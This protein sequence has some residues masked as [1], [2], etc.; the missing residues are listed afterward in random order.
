MLT[1]SSTCVL[2][3]INILEPTC[4]S[5]AAA[6]GPAQGVNISWA[7][8]TKQNC[9]QQ[10]RQPP[11]CPHPLMLVLTLSLWQSK[12]AGRTLTQHPMCFPEIAMVA[13]Q[14]SS[15]VHDTAKVAWSALRDSRATTQ[16]LQLLWLNLL[17]NYT[18]KCAWNHEFHWFSSPCLKP[19]QTG[20][21][22]IIIQSQFCLS[23]PALSGCGDIWRLGAK[24]F[25]LKQRES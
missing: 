14:K 9:G 16:P 22:K 13:W 2:T 1:L 19:E 18:R 6:E 17:L 4:P 15:A 20:Q 7:E 3:C 25:F 23:A 10:P 11:G 5:T 8:P 21:K 12:A 24:G